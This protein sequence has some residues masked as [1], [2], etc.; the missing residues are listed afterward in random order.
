MVFDR[1]GVGCERQLG[2]GWIAMDQVNA[3]ARFLASLLEELAE[4][5]SGVPLKYSLLLPDDTTIIS[6]SVSRGREMRIWLRAGKD[7]Q[8]FVVMQDE[9]LIPYPQQRD[10][11]CQGHPDKHAESITCR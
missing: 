10:K 11:Q 8:S 7:I 9:C 1:T 6:P 4:T 2:V 3:D 5:S